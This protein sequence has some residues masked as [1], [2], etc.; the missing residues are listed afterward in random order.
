MGIFLTFENV[1]FFSSFG[2]VATTGETISWDGRSQ[3]LTSISYLQWL[4]V[5]DI[6]LL[7]NYLILSDNNTNNNGHIFSNISGFP[8]TFLCL[9]VQWDNQQEINKKS[10]WNQHEINL[11][12][13][14]KLP[15]LAWIHWHWSTILCIPSWKRECW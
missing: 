9:A 2:L 3:F 5:S 12:S 1:C 8:S 10:T 14:R 13:T 7:L 4:T 15:T 11:K 6:R